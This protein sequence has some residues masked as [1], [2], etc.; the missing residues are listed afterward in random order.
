[1]ANIQVYLSFDDFM[2]V[3]P[4]NWYLLIGIHLHLPVWKPGRNQGKRLRVQEKAPTYRLNEFYSEFCRDNFA[5]PRFILTLEELSRGTFKKEGNRSDFEHRH[6]LRSRHAPLLRRAELPTYHL[7][8]GGRRG[9]AD[10]SR[11][12]VLRDRQAVAAAPGLG[13]LSQ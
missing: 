3:L 6:I 10:D 7:D 2:H 12:D 11:D 9:A 1:V 5:L 4:C 8:L 13:A